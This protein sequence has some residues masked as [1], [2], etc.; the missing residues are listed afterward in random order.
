MYEKIL[1]LMALAGSAVYLLEWL[2]TKVQAMFPKRPAVIPVTKSQKLEESSKKEP[3][4]ESPTKPDDLKALIEL[5]AA[6]GEEMANMSRLIAEANDR[7]AALETPK[8]K[9]TRKAPAKAT[10]LAPGLGALPPA[11]DT[12][13]YGALPPV[14]GGFEPVH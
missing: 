13:G 5:L 14:T 3:S 11:P 2:V 6:Q 9:A 7:L 12:E 10:S 8:T 4:L 1:F